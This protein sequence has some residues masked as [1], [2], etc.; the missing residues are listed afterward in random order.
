MWFGT[1]WGLSRFGGQNWRT[2][3]GWDD[4]LLNNSINALA[5]APDGTLWAATPTGVSHYA[6][7]E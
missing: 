3:G 4:N 2:F 7:V 5:L 1:N 6:L